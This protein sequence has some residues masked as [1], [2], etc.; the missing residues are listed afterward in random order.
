MHQE[1]TNMLVQEANKIIFLKLL[2]EKT[3]ITNCSYSHY[4][5]F[6]VLFANSITPVPIQAAIVHIVHI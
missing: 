4:S 3:N 5:R 2:F 1:E 6:F